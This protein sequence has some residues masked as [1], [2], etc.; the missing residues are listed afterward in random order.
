MNRTRVITLLAS[1]AL[2]LHLPAAAVAQQSQS[3]T[4]PLQRTIRENRVT[5]S[6]ESDRKGQEP[7]DKPSGQAMDSIL[8]STEDL[9][10]IR[11]AYL[12]VLSGDGCSPEVAARVAELRALL[13]EKKAAGAT[14]SLGATEK[15]AAELEGAMLA[16]ALD[17]YKRPPV[18]SASTLAPAGRDAEH[19]RLLEAALSPQQQPAAAAAGDRAAL[20]AE[21][22]K[23]LASCHSPKR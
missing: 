9:S 15:S 1:A 17:W 23:L 6:R 8:S 16:L 20:K 5:T 13:G 2:F 18:E 19:A 10:S 21:L 4:D 12:R 22:D 14:A 11:D 7:A 3:T